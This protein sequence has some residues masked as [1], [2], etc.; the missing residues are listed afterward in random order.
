[1]NKRFLLAVVVGCFFMLS[2]DNFCMEIKKE[3]NPVTVKSDKDHF[4]EII[5]K[6]IGLLTVM[7][8]EIDKI[9]DENNEKN[10]RKLIAHICKPLTY[11]GA[12]LIY[13][14]SKDVRAC[15]AQILSN[16]PSNI[17]TEGKMIFKKFKEN[18]QGPLKILMEEIKT[19]REPP[20]YY[21]YE[22]KNVNVLGEEFNSNL[23]GDT[24]KKFL[25]IN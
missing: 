22:S 20:H 4:S 7:L 5:S 16:F 18:F 10:H 21:K 15:A 24:I 2:V 11:V 1:M 9:G 8:K 3:E 12:N 14:R 23:K 19:I 17:C 6:S 25:D 13:T